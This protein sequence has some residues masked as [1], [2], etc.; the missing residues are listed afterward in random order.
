MG[1]KYGGIQVA[2]KQGDRPR[3][4]KSIEPIRDLEDIRR[5]KKILE[6]KPRDL[7]LFDL[8]TQT[9]LMIKDLLTLKVKDFVG[10]KIGDLLTVTRGSKTGPHEIRLNQ[11]ILR[12]FNLYLEKSKPKPDDYLFK[13]RKGGK[14]LNISSV[15][16]LIKGWLEAANIKGPRGAKSLRKTWELSIRSGLSNGPK[17]PAYSPSTKILEPIETFTLQERVYDQL[18]QAIIT[19]KIPP[20]S[21][22][23]A[24][25]ISA[26]FNVSQMPVRD[27]L[28]RLE[29]KGFVTP[30][31]NR[32]IVV[33]ELTEENLREITTIRI[34][35][36]SLAAEQA[37]KNRTEETLEQLESLLRAYANAKNPEELFRVNKEFHYTIYRDADMPMLQEFI[38]GLWDRVSPYLH[39]W[40]LTSESITSI[41]KETLKYHQGMLDGMR[42]KNPEEV[43]KWVKTDLSSGE[44]KIKEVLKNIAEK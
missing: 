25:E 34:T 42:G 7:L 12:S 14:P 41:T 2:R 33:T 18:F 28:G 22:L 15:S 37:C 39:L 11:V 8:A 23:T 17:S 6:D 32:G 43:S 4:P 27:A 24:K 29:A 36:E 35:L 5:I 31:K 30:Q 38:I 20:G 3:S 13:S 1:T 44:V 26:Q 21:R 16:H 10:L 19:S 9:G 40:I